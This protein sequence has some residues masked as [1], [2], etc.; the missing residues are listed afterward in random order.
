MPLFGIRTTNGVE[1]ENNALL[2]NNLRQMTVEKS[3][4]TY[5]DRY[6]SI[7]QSLLLKTIK[8]KS[9]GHNV[10]G[11]ARKLLGGEVRKSNLCRAVPCGSSKGNN[12]FNVINSLTDSTYIVDMDNLRCTCAVADQ[13][14][15][16]CR[17]ILAVLKKKDEFHSTFN[18]IHENYKI[19]QIRTVLERT[20]IIMPP[21]NDGLNSSSIRPPPR[22]NNGGREDATWSR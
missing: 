16:P 5:I 6:L 13:V 19:E 8:L 17:H 20:T 10:W 7:Q 11:H 12:L 2:H 14:K 3:L 22:Y 18:F 9:D 4:I 15:I 1:G 21:T